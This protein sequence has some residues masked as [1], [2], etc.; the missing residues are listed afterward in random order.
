MVCFNLLVPLI[1]SRYKAPVWLRNAHMATVIPSVYRT[2]EGI[3]YNRERIPTPDDDFLDL[4]WSTV[5]SKQL[6]I[7]S[8]GLEGSSDRSYMLG[9]VRYGNQHNWDALA[10]NCRSCSGEMNKKPRFYH[11]GD[12]SDLNTVIKH[13]LTKGYDKIGLVGFSLGGSL[14]L[15]WMGEKSDQVDEVVGAVAYSTPI[16][17]LSSVEELEKPS[18]SFY[19]KRFLKKLDEKIRLKS[20]MFPDVISYQP[21][22]DFKTFSQFDNLYT[23]PLHGFDDAFDFYEKA[24]AERYMYGTKKPVLL[25]NAWNDPFFGPSCYP[26]KQC[27]QHPFLYLETPARGGHVG[28]SLGKEYN[29]MEK[30]AI[31][32]LNSI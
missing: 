10:W 14:T 21:V 11:H 29:Y 20:A 7:L 22:K 31:E 27:E 30:R 12:D 2:V 13:A 25:V 19:K 17:L 1:Q 9:M 6:I 16:N 24:S 4:D 15:K 3:Q 26:V 23:A 32:F 8:H 28:F 18:K 5:D